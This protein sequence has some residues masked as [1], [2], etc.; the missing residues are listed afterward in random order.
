MAEAHRCG[1]CGGKNHQAIS[2]PHLDKGTRCFRCNGF[3]HISKQ[4]KST[5][6]TARDKS[7]N[8]SSK[9]REITDEMERAMNVGLHMS[10]WKLR[11]SH[12]KVKLQAIICMEMTES[13]IRQSGIGLQTRSNQSTESH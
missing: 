7:S 10:S 5:D 2:C 8:E 1:N 6:V 12:G 11:V 13:V 9:D 3:G 4:C